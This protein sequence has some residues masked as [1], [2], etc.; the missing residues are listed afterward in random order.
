M[1]AIYHS[2]IE[3]FNAGDLEAAR[4]F[5]SQAIEVIAIMSRCGGMSAG[6]AMMKLIGLDCGP[7]RAPLQQPS[8]DAIA[9]LTRELQAVGFP[10]STNRTGGR[11]ETAPAAAMVQ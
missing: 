8:P 11:A 10:V 2:V 5:Q 4:R 3:A 1:P 6:K 7:V 9:S